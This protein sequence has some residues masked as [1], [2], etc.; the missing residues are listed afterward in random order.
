[1]NLDTLPENVSYML[2]GMYEMGSGLNWTIRRKLWK[3]EKKW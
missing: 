1:M 2:S 3:K